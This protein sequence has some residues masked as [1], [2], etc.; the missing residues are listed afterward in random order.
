MTEVFNNGNYGKPSFSFVV[1]T[2]ISEDDWRSGKKE[3]PLLQSLS[4]MTLEEVDV[5][6]FVFFSNASGLPSCYNRAIAEICRDNAEICR[7]NI[8]IPRFTV[9]AHDDITMRDA[10]I[11]DKII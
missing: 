7:D 4:K 11:F 1:A 6:V 5:R 2:Q 9:F 10:L 3:L 8:E